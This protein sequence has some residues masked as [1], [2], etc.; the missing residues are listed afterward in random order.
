MNP[1]SDSTFT[2]AATIALPHSTILTY[3][4]TKSPTRVR[5]VAA[6]GLWI[7]TILAALVGGSLL[8]AVA[9]EWMHELRQITS[10]GEFVDFV[11][12]AFR[13]DPSSIILVVIPPP[14]AVVLACCIP[15]V[16][17]GKKFAC[18]LAIISLIPL[19]ILVVFAGAALVG[20]AFVEGSGLFPG[21]VNRKFLWFLVPAIISLFLTLLLKDLIAFLLW[22]GK[23][24]AT[25]KHPVPFLPRRAATFDQDRPS[26]AASSRPL[27]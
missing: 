1:G 26:A 8:Y 5:I 4:D 23:N 9:Q 19:L 17:R 16:R 10:L 13:E 6:R 18:V 11:E 3:F 22:I 21:G 15:A 14:I 7:V 25:E 27:P 12:D 24:P 20:V 2:R